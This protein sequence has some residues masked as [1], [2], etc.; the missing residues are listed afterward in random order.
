MDLLFS[1]FKLNEF[2]YFQFVPPADHI[3][4]VNRV[5]CIFELIQQNYSISKLLVNNQAYPKTA[6]V[7]DAELQHPKIL[8]ILL[9]REWVEVAIVP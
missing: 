7:F 8:M 1:F 2:I 4:H 6:K 3:Y 9:V 5:S